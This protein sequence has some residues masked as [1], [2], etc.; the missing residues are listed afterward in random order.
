MAGGC[1]YVQ[2][3]LA[4]ARWAP[5]GGPHPCP[6]LC[7]AVPAPRYSTTACTQQSSGTTVVPVDASRLCLVNVAEQNGRLDPEEGPLSWHLSLAT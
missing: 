1:L 4:A 3:A 5:A 2:P 7:L 6:L